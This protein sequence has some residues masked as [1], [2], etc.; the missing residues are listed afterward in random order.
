MKVLL[1]RDREAGNNFAL[2]WWLEDQMTAAL[3]MLAVDIDSRF[4]FHLAMN[5]YNAVII[6]KITVNC[7]N[8]NCNIIPP[9]FYG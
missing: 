6:I 9:K 8:Y 4:S 3:E 7:Y 1:D 2:E 5:F